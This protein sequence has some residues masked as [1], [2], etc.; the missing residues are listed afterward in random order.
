MW[1]AGQEVKENGGAFATSSRL[2]DLRRARS[3]SS[4]TELDIDYEMHVLED[5]GQYHEGGWV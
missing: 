2:N 5:T 1:G 3:T 4:D